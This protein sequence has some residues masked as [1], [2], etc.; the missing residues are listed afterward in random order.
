MNLPR[1]ARMALLCACASSRTLALELS[2]L[3]K[4]TD[5]VFAPTNTTHVVDLS[6]A[7]EGRWDDATAS[8]DHGT[9]DPQKWAIVFK[10]SSVHVPS[11][12]TVTFKNHPS[13]APVVWLVEGDVRI[14]GVV[15]LSGGHIGESLQTEPG[16]GGFRGAAEPGVYGHGF[17]HAAGLGL[18]G[19]DNNNSGEGQYSYGN[20]RIVPLIGGS[21]GRA[22]IRAGGSGGGAILIASERVVAIDGRVAADGGPHRPGVSNS[23]SAGAIRIVSESLQGN[24]SLSAVSSYWGRIRVEAR[25]FSGGMRTLPQTAV[26]APDNPPRIWPESNHPEVAVV[27]VGG[28]EAVQDPRANL[29]M[30]GTD[31]T[32]LPNP[33]PD[34]VA[35][36]VKTRNLNAETTK[37]R[38]RIVPVAG[39]EGKSL[40]FEASRDTVVGADTFWIANCR[41]PVGYNAFQVIAESP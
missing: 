14:D 37:V 32:L 17:G 29:D 38:I 5:G 31:I 26:V 40:W 8:N 36:R 15:N 28:I 18:G 12:V 25:S 24:G 22:Y 33:T 19:G 2:Y 7:T 13:R 41:F 4:G 10:F 30:N 20:S 6:L 34:S 27:S 9:Y 11:G 16:P 39:E 21:G 35:V 23:G 3:N 1:L